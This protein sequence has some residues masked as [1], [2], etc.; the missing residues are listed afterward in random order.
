MTGQRIIDFNFM[1]QV[2]SEAN[3]AVKYPRRA[4]SGSSGKTW[5]LLCRTQG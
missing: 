5:K 3:E 2:K 1:Y 4:G